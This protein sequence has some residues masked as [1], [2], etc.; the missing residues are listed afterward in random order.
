[1]NSAD[2]KAA[3]A[4]YKDKKVEA[5]I[6]VL[7]C[8]PAGTSWVGSAPN[9]ATILNR[10]KFDL[11][12]GKHRN[13]DLQQAWTTLGGDSFVFEEVEVLEQDLP[14]YVQASMLKDRLAHWQVELKAQ[15]L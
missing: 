4:A 7:R 12:L 10:I 6:F 13:H 2:R 15:L 3:V 8:T 11:G 1:M 14:S 5:G 9:L